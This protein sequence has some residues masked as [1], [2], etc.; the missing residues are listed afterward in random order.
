MNAGEE[1][2]GEESEVVHALLDAHADGDAPEGDAPEGG[3]AGGGVD[4]RGGESLEILEVGAPCFSLSRTTG[5]L[6]QKTKSLC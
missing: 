5:M 2:G 4:R 1:L 3:E 6:S